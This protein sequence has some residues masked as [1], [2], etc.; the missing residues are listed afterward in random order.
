MIQSCCRI[1]CYVLGRIYL[2]LEHKF[3]EQKS[4]NHIY[5][6][7]CVLST[8]DLVHRDCGQPLPQ[9][10]QNQCHWGSTVVV[11]MLYGTSLYT[12]CCRY[13]TVKYNTILNMIRQSESQNFVQTINRQKTPYTSPLHESYGATFVSSLDILCREICRVHC[14]RS[15]FIEIRLC[16]DW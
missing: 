5:R 2:N 10:R 16:V 7:I 3:H 11:D 4:E 9:T 14:I 1:E 15:W 8:N 12:I 13:I 6:C